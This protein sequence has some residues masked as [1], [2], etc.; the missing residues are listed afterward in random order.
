MDS[1]EIF[2]KLCEWLKAILITIL[3]VFADA[4]ILY[5]ITV[6]LAY[7]LHIDISRGYGYGC[8][9]DAP[10]YLIFAFKAF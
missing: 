4:V 5:I 1:G 9:Y 8:G 10:Q 6:A 7:F 3:I 2:A